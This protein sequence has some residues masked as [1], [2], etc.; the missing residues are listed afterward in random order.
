MHTFKSGTFLGIGG[1]ARH[2][3]HHLAGYV[4]NH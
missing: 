2:V 1:D 4:R 3:A